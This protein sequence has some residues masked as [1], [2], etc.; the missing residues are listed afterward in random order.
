MWRHL[1]SAK[2]VSPSRQ[3]VLDFATEIDRKLGVFDPP[4]L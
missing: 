1:L 3:A 4:V 2:N